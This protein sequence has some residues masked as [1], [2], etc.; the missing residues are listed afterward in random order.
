VTEDDPVPPP[1]DAVLCLIAGLVNHGDLR[2]LGLSVLI[3]GRFIGGTAISAR[4]W[5]NA[6]AELARRDS[7]GALGELM[8]V[9]GGLIYPSESETAATEGGAI[10]DPDELPPPA[11]FVHLTDAIEIRPDG[12]QVMF[13]S[14]MRIA[15]A[16]VQA[17]QWGR[18]P[19]PS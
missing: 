7:A 16:Q 5:L 8:E 15:I 10:D 17:W 12:G 14:P 3:G 6:S 1:P 2:D 13:S 4:R 19:P 11:F 9:V 18:P